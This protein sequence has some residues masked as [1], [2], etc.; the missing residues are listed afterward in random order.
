M[1]N[2]SYK[3]VENYKYMPHKKCLIQGE[4][5]LDYE[6]LYNMVSNFKR[7][8]EESGIKKELERL[9]ARMIQRGERD[10]ISVGVIRCQARKSFFQKRK[11][12]R[13]GK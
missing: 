10:N 8:L 1:N 6:Q 7:Y 4:R 12:R 9:I 5:Q 13:S 11:I 3:L 2:L